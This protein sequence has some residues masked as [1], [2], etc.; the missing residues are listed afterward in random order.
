MNPDFALKTWTVYFD[1]G[2]A[3]LIWERD[4]Q[5]VGP[6]VGM[7][8]LHAGDM[9][10]IVPD[11]MGKELDDL[12]CVWESSKPDEVDW[13]TFH[14]E[15]LR[16]SALIALWVAPFNILVRYTPPYEDNRF[17]AYDSELWMDPGTVAR[18]AHGMPAL[19]D[20]PESWNALLRLYG[21][22]DLN[23]LL[24]PDDAKTFPTIGTTDQGCAL[25]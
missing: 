11:P 20:D 22:G 3:P 10:D 18:L 7:L 15:A 13:L 5:A 12:G 14:Q 21:V 23:S 24:L 4:G 1:Y 2:N 8:L 25:S 16:L 6:Y 19:Q 9:N 17:D